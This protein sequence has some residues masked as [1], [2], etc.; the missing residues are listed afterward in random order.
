MKIAKQDKYCAFCGALL[1]GRQ[2]KYCSSTCQRKGFLKPVQTKTC[3]YCRQEFIPGRRQF[4]GRFCSRKCSGSYYGKI[5]HENKQRI[6]EQ[7]IELYKLKNETKRLSAELESLKKRISQIK[8]CEICNEYMIARKT[9]QRMCR[10]CAKKTDNIRRDRRLYRNGKPDLSITLEK[11]YER[12]LGI[13][14]LCNSFIIFGN[15]TNADNYPSI[16][17]IKPLSKGGLHSW[18]NV[19]LVCR[20]CNTLKGN[21]EQRNK[22]K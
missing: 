7:K 16:D 18:D 15:D 4:V 20:R 6:E 3:L 8:I 12:D 22:R 5:K 1:R 19:Q 21:K 17:H 13:C 14:Q 9:T 10:A 11:V 2:K